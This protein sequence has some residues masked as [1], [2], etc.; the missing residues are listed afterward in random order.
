MLLR[1]SQMNKFEKVFSDGHQMSL[2]GGGAGGPMSGER[3]GTWYSE[4]QCIMGNGHIGLPWSLCQQTDMT[5]N[6]TFA[7]LR[8]RGV[9][10]G[11]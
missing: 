2:T 9:K 4:V 1:G 10:T 3:V 6:I 5:E 11:I 7:Q 8:W